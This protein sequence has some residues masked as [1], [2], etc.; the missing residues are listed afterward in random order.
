MP[1]AAWIALAGIAV[2]I[3]LQ[4]L[5]F[6]YFIGKLSE[7]VDSLS[8]AGEGHGDVALAFAEFKGSV[9]ATMT[10][11]RDTIASLDRSMQGVNRQL[12]NLATKGGFHVLTDT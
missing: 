3:L 5:L 6:A 10:A 7:K 4:S 9:E 1:H 11:Q 8:K 12:A 2:T